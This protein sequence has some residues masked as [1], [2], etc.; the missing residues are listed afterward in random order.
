MLPKSKVGI[1][2]P[3]VSKTQYDKIQNLIKKGIEE[4]ATLSAGGPGRPK[5]LVKGYF[6]STYSI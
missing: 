3:V 6:V 2:G 1:Y 5:H 4:G